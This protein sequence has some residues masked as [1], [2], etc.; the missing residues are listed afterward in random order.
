MG[1]FTTFMDQFS[2]KAKVEK[3]KV[4]FGERATASLA[5]GGLGAM[6]G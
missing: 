2:Q 6:I 4:T 1:L 5:A 3:R